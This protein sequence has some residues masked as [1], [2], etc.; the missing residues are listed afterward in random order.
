MVRSWI[1]L[2]PSK[3]LYLEN[4]VLTLNKF[5]ELKKRDEKI[6]LLKSEIAQ[7]I[8]SRDDEV[9]ILSK[10]LADAITNGEVR[11]N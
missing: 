8:E 10:R 1:E 2:K 3:N 5:S 7:M 11:K 9:Q 6:A 4:N